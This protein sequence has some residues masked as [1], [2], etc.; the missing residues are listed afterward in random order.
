MSTDE[1]MKAKWYLLHTMYV[2][3]AFK[4]KE[5]LLFV[6]TWMNLRDLMFSEIS[7]T[8]KDRYYMIPLTYEESK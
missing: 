1:Q 4:K 3:S 5:I 6:T 2:Y 8:Q 7:Q